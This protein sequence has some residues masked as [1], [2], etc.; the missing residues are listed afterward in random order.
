M[1][2]APEDEGAPADAYSVVVP[3]VGRPG[4]EWTLRPLLDGAR[5]PEEI[6]VVDDR[7]APNG[8]PPGAAVPGVTLLRSG[9]RGPACARDIGWR[10]TATP[11]VAFL[12]DDVLPDADWTAALAADLAACHSGVGASQGRID[13]PP[14]PG[15]R[16]TDAERATLAL[17]RA[18]WI[19]ADMAYRRAAL[20]AADGFD[21]RFNRAYR[22]DTDLALR[23]LDAGY[24]LTAGTR[25]SIHPVVQDARPWRSVAAQAGNADDALMRRLHGPGWRKRVGEPGGTLPRHVLTTAALAD[26]AAAA[27]V[28]AA[29]AR[30]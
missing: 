21:R 7:P 18:R 24:E 30:A 20:E 22:E 25:R 12:D 15:R 6:V 1:H 29:A 27:G 10:H 4:L 9:G 16:P 23:V 5:A 8:P 17:A 14:P 3:T 28:R 2:R 26:A 13:V 11:W 19:T